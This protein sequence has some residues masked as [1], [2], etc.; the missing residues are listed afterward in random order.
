MVLSGANV[1]LTVLVDAAR[2]AA[3]A[4][5]ADEAARAWEQVRAAQPDHP[6][7][8]FFFGQ[9]ALLQGDAR[10]AL[11][12]LQRAALSAPKDALIPLSLA[13]AHRILGDNEGEM[14]AFEAALKA[15]PYCYPALL[16]KGALLEKTGFR[17]QAA[18]AFGDALKIAPAEERLSADLR[19]LV[20]RARASV[21][22]NTAALDAFLES[23]LGDLRKAHADARLDRFDECKDAM[24]GRKRIYV[25]QPVM[26]HYPRLPAIQFYDEAGFPWLR[27]LEAA[28]DVIESELSALLTEGAQGI[29]PYMNHPDGVPLNDAAALN[30]SPDWSAYFL[31]DDG[32]RMDDHCKRCPKTTA[33][34]ES[35]PLAKVPGFAP[36]VFFSIL[37]ARAHI[38][39]HTGVT[40]T[41][42][43]THLGLIVPDGCVFRVGNDTREWRRGKAW[44][45]DDT[46][47]H[48]AKN[49]SDRLRAL[50]IFDVWNP[51]LSEAEREL[52]CALLAAQREYYGGDVRRT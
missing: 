17:R 36:A 20:T 42:L 4:G 41:R 29:R 35:L 13:N 6:E 32:L 21:A 46:I 12:W 49:N 5:R 16:G 40:N 10:G 11:P 7:A 47:E 31:W 25:Q 50:L 15:D 34:V 26:L 23:K 44:I 33:L 45:F 22:E 14:A 30:R 37:T 19:A 43:I 9:R 27:D 52:V 8:S 18:R 48:E 3:R 28:T 38:P 51:Y 2:R 24:T 39:P 1:A